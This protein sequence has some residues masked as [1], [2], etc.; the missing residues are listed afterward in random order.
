M[1][2]EVSIQNQLELR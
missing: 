1:T 2:G